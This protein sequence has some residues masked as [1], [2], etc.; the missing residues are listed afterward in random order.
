MG[1]IAV[2]DQSVAELIAAGEVIERPASIVKEVLE[3]SI[4]AGAT[5]IVVEIRNGGR[6]YI[7][8]TDN[9]SGI[10]GDDMPVAFLRHATSKLQKEADL[11]SIA[12]LGFRG[13]ALASICAVSEVEMTSKTKDEEFGNILR[14]KAGEQILFEQTG[15]PD[16]TTL[17]IRNL[18][19]NVP[20]RLKFLKKDAAE[21]SAVTSVVEKIMLSHPEISFRYLTD[22]TV[23][24]SGGGDGELL[25]SVQGVFGR[26]FA[27]AM[28]PV[29][30]SFNGITVTGVITRPDAGRATRGMQHFYVND[31][32]V[33]SKTCAAA[34]EDAYKGSIMVGKFP[35]CVLNVNM[36][37][38]MV[39]VN[40]HPAK[41]EIRFSDEKAVYDA[42]Y[43]AIKNTLL[44]HDAL[45]NQMERS[46]SLAPTPK[47]KFGTQVEFDAKAPKLQQTQTAP[48]KYRNAFG[49]N[50][51]EK[52]SEPQPVNPIDAESKPG[53]VKQ[54]DPLIPLLTE[55]EMSP[56]AAEPWKDEIPSAEPESWKN[57]ILSIA[58]EDEPE[59]PVLEPVAVQPSHEPVHAEQLPEVSESYFYIPKQ[60][61]DAGLEFRYVGELFATYVLVECGEQLILIDKHA[62]HERMLYEQYKRQFGMGDSQLLMV[63]YAV[64]VSA[65]EFDLIFSQRE[66]L[67]KKGFTFDD[68]GNHTLLI[69]SVPPVLS[70]YEPF[71]PL[72]EMA[73]KSAIGSAEL[74]Q[75]IDEMLHEMACKAAVKAHDIN[76]GQEL[77]HLARELFLDDTIRH[78]PHGRPVLQVISKQEL[79][80]KFGRIV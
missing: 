61:A 26:E 56:V 57:E 28:I 45:Q 12:T 72:L 29:N 74:P 65:E 10:A 22:G 30:Y 46:V 32:F 73:K 70:S 77:L 35:G 36:E 8:V 19:Y 51:P 76:A 64:S 63:P 39:D 34:L 41:I 59:M 37:Y 49:P 18:F 27:L 44:S 31:R 2:L 25:S 1:R 66:Y 17:I 40:V 62:A 69:R 48:G 4:D 13:E 71:T 3:N 68:F 20:A 50:Q 60:D 78:C 55:Q 11:Q 58:V 67:E 80:R 14:M 9:G 23:R 53:K 43:F 5:H 79:D 75:C 6:S 47:E 24:I 42:M 52:A 38:S 33:K 7:R 54:T 16:G 15:C 21:T